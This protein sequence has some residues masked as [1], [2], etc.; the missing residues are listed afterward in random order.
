MSHSHLA[1]R[2]LIRKLELSPRRPASREVPGWLSQL[3]QQLSD[4]FEPFQG[5]AR[6]GYECAQ[7]D[8][9]W[10]VSLFLGQHEFVGG[11]ED[12]EQLPVNFRFNLSGLTPAFELVESLSW[13][14]FPAGNRCFD[15]SGDLSFISVSGRA[16]GQAVRVS[17]Q[18]S[19]PEIAGP[20]LR[21]HADGRVEVV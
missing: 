8:G 16:A 20:G 3:I 9:V 11:P 10:E 13:N 6:V 4:L 19:P 7:V 18:S 12:G 14:A 2:H 1:V 17:I 15:D 5:V 21:E